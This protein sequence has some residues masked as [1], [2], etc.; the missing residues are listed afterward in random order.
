MRPALAVLLVGALA[1]VAWLAASVA[2][3]EH[4]TAQLLSP[5][6]LA[7]AHAE[8][9][10]DENCIRCHAS[11]R[12][13]PQQRCL[14]CH[15]DLG[16]RIRAGRGLHGTT[17]RGQACA[18]RCHVEHRG[19]GAHLVRWP[20]GGMNA[21]DHA[22]TGWRLEGAHVRA[23]C[24]QCHRG[25]NARGNRTFLDT[26]RRCVTCHQ[27]IHAGRLG[28]ACQSCHDQTDFRHA[29]RRDFSHDQARFPLRG[30]HRSVE[31]AEC[32]GTPPRWLG[33]P[34]TTCASCHN[35]PHDGRLGAQ[36]AS[37]HNEFSWA[38][39]RGFTHPG[40]SLGGGH[41]G[42]ACATC[43]D[44]GNTQ[45][46][47][48][49]AR[50]VGCHHPVHEAPFGNQCESCH[51]GIAWFGVPRGVG[52]AAHARTVFPLVGEH[53]EVPCAAC[54]RA[55]L[56][57]NERYRGLAFERC[58]DCHADVHDGEFA[59]RDR[60]EC[61]ACH[62]PHGFHPTTFGIAEHASTRFPL[63]GLHTA[64]ACA[65]CHGDARP[66]YSLQVADRACASC[67]E[68]PHGNQFRR[69]MAQGGC[70]HCHDAT[71]WTETRVAHTTWP[72]TGRHATA[73]CAGCHAP[74]AA[75]RAAGRT[76]NR[77]RGVPRDCA[78]C[79]DDVHAGQFRSSEPLR[80]CADCH[81][82]SAF[83]L[84]DWDHAGMT[85]FALDGRHQAVACAGC[86]AT[87]TLRNGDHSVRYRLG[88]RACRDCHADPHAAPEGRS[89]ESAQW[90]GA[91][92]DPHAARLAQASLGPAAVIDPHAALSSMHAGSTDVDAIHG[93]WGEPPE[94]AR[95]RLM[96]ELAEW[97]SP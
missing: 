61:G 77:Y 59:S 73:P 17:Y 20:S 72:L 49:G 69:E 93:A 14:S 47:S 46:P 53:P 80:E 78:G 45:A 62:T 94:D 3:P 8:L 15:D 63:T 5:G 7:R 32:H 87:E 19:V 35:D 39:T 27:D 48:R 74:S 9:E 23:E 90:T 24:R 55:E 96:R 97:V 88:Y 85:G 64:V 22:D 36:C 18:G 58:A 38:D 2:R 25:V 34:F 42:V 43:H 28:T 71:G 21:F 91:A 44:R 75:E 60:G 82:T 79:H 67:H 95:A 37:C 84:P 12:Q 54:H 33:I 13:V 68:N 41:Q 11:G 16:A 31:C 4:G 26:D 65:G 66:R 76:E 6:R 10:G 57:R 86:H 1:L 92:Q 29:N 50:C 52:L 56:P 70:A 40:L 81:V 83:T 51:R 30:A 89:A